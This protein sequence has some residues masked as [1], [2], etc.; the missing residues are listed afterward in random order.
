MDPRGTLFVHAKAGRTLRQAPADIGAA[1]LVD[2]AGAFGAGDAVWVVVRGTDGGQGVF[3]TAI[4]AG[5]AAACR[6]AT[7]CARV[8]ALLWPV[9]R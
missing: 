4:A 1:D 3:A 2:A 6:V 9:R 7:P 8:V 5:D